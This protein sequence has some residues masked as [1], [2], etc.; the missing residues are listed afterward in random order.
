M[1]APVCH[2]TT[3]QTSP[4]PEPDSSS[5]WKHCSVPDCSEFSVPYSDHSRYPILYNSPSQKVERGWVLSSYVHA[6]RIL[7]NADLGVP[8]G[9]APM[10]V[11]LFMVT[12]AFQGNPDICCNYFQPSCSQMPVMC[13][14]PP[15]QVSQTQGISKAQDG[16][17]L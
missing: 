17:S 14:Q 13:Y 8:A 9:V 15:A 11:C 4:K 10:P 16:H 1:E 7:G 3:L 5:Y 12:S 6:D 2:H